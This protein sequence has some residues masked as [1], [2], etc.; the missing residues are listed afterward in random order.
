[1][2]HA[3]NP[4]YLVAEIRWIKDQSQLGDSLQDPIS[5]ITREDWRCGSSSKASALQVLGACNPSYLGGRDQE[6]Q[7]LKPA[8]ANSF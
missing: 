2:A 4:S 3:C 5:K 6:D 1:V 7:S 8:W